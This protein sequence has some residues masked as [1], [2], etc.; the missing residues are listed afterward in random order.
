MTQP[1][2]EWET[3]EA[4]HDDICNGAIKHYEQLAAEC[5]NW[6]STIPN[7]IEFY[8]KFGKKGYIDALLQTET[9]KA[10]E[11]ERGRV[12][13]SIELLKGNNGM[14]QGDRLIEVIGNYDNSNLLVLDTLLKELK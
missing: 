6:M 9:Q 10:R 13:Y 11:E 2:E 1:K 14:I 4:T 12:I 5:S 8:R 3:S 7:A